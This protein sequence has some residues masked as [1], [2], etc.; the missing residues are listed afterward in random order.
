MYTGYFLRY[1]FCNPA[2]VTQ[3]N[4]GAQGWVRKKVLN[5]ALSLKSLT[6]SCPWANKAINSKW[7]RGNHPS[8]STLSYTVFQSVLHVVGMFGQLCECCIFSVSCTMP[9]LE[10]GTVGGGTVLGPQSACLKVML[11]CCS[12]ACSDM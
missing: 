5:F 1:E 12:H 3:N 4:S 10:V 11:L 8:P 9:S 2:F 7:G 6:S